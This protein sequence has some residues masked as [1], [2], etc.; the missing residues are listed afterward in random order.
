MVIVVQRVLEASVKVDGRVVGEIGKGLLLLVGVA[1]GDTTASAERLALQVSKL[2]IFG[3][4]DGKMG[5]NLADAGG[6]V[7]AVSQFTLLGDFSKGNRPSFHRAARPE[8]ARPIFETCLA[9]LAD[10]TGRPV[11]T[12]VFGADMRVSLVNDG[13][14][15]FVLES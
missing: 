6:S 7:L 2:R 5:L 13:P 9:A 8:A 11:A 15:T 12:G 10:A 1:E 4:A 14:V 3:D